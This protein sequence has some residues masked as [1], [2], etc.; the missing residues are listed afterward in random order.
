MNKTQRLIILVGNEENLREAIRCIKGFKACTCVKHLN[1]EIIKN[2][3]HHNKNVV[4]AVSVYD[5][6][7]SVYNPI[8]IR[9]V[10]KGTNVNAMRLGLENVIEDFPRLLDAKNIDVGDHIKFDS[11]NVKFEPCR[12]MLCRIVAGN[13]IRPEHILYESDN[14]FVVPGLGAFFDGYIML[15]PKRHVMSFA[16]LNDEEFDEFLV[17]MNDLRFILESIY[18]K[19]VFAFECG[20]GKGGKGKH[21]TSIVHAHFHFAVTDMPVLKCIQKSGIHPGLIDPY[22]LRQYGLHPYMLYVDQ[23]DNWYF[24]SD[25]SV[26]YFP[27]QHPRQVLADYMGLKKGEYNWRTHPHEEKM[28]IIAEEFYSFIRENFETLPQWIQ[29][30]TAKYAFPKKDRT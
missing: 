24:I 19:K 22:D 4:H 6:S 17:V 14:F 13:P 27:R 2:V 20:S 23:C 21:E 9:V 10:K 30:A 28:D 26:N 29:D 25:D 5:F 8:I 16:E 3:F 15:V 12:C 7:L 1:R 11:H 18:H